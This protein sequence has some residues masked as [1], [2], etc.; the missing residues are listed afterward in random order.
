MF[1]H[2]SSETGSKLVHTPLKLQTLNDSFLLTSLLKNVF[3]VS[4]DDFKIKKLA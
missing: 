1:R 3:F 2:L 4:I